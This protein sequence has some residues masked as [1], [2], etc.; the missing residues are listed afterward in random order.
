MPDIAPVASSDATA[1]QFRQAMSLLAGAVNVVATGSVAGGPAT[2]HGMTATAVCSVCAEPPSIVVCLNR[3]AGTYRQL[4][5]QGVFSVNVLSTRHIPIAQ[6]FAGQDSLVGADRFKDL[7]WAQGRL[8]V[9]V[10]DDA[11][12]SLECRTARFIEHGTHAL[13][14]GHVEVASW[15]EPEQDAEPLVYH[16][17]RFV[18]ITN[19]ETKGGERR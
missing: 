4:V 7:G 3:E 12:A 5:A 14:I 19:F 6:T 15:V 18:G 9:P 11:L 13:I 10:L 17:R 2:W 1:S 8:G 16:G